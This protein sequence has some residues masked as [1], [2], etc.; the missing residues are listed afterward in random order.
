MAPGL[1]IFLE[2]LWGE[3]KESNVDLVT[4]TAGSGANNKVDAQILSLG[5]SFQ[6]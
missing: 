2:Y 1:A 3:V 5:V 6:W 4:G